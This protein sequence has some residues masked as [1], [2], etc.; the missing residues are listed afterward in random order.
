M[1]A[2]I[3]YSAR[4]RSR[5]DHRPLDYYTDSGEEETAGE[6]ND[7]SNM[8]RS[9][10]IDVNSHYAGSRRGS[11]A[12]QYLSP[13]SQPLVIKIL[14]LGDAATGKTAVMERYMHDRF[15]SVHNPTIAV[16]FS[17]KLIYIGRKRVWLSLSTL[18]ESDEGTQ[19]VNSNHFQN[20]HGIFIV[21]D[22]A[23]NITLER[24]LQWKALIDETVSDNEVNTD[25]ESENYPISVVILANKV[26]MIEEENVRFSKSRMDSLCSRFNIDHWFATSAKNNTNIDLAVKQMVLNILKGPYREDF[27]GITQQDIDEFKKEVDELWAEVI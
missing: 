19:M 26:D 3:P 21:A 22:I 4:K 23:N 15:T 24:I 13:T 18:V 27:H 14:F 10:S 11:R 9:M 17:R 2:A 1:P 8:H 16:D 5:S 20:V 7:Q 12:Y 6:T 25:V